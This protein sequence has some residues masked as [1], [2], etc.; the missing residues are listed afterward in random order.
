M[1]KPQDFNFDE[2]IENKSV[3]F[4]YDATHPFSNVFLS[5]VT[6]EGVEY[7]T[8]EHAYQAQKFDRSAQDVVDQIL[9][10]T[11]PVEAKDIADA[12]LERMRPDWNYFT[13]FRVMKKIVYEKMVQN[14]KILKLLLKSGEKNLVENGPHDDCWG[15]VTVDGIVGGH[16]FIGRILM[17]VRSELRNES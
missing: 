12:N 11:D 4:F 6:Y 7:L 8:S 9:N 13:K 2:A 1:P 14:P 17:R 15:A 10:T 5:T 3:I 16:N